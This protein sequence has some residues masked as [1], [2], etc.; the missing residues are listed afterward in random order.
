MDGTALVFCEGA[1]GQPEGKTANGLVRFGD[2][3]DILGVVDSTTA[4]KDAGDIL[5]D[6]TRPIPI[7]DT[8]ASAIE[9]LDLKPD[10]L[11]VGLNPP[12]G[13]MPPKY[14]KVIREALKLGISVDSALR[15]YL[16][17]DAEFPGLA[18]MT[19]ST[20]RSVGYPKPIDQLRPYTGEIETVEA[21][22]VAVVGT[23]S[24]VGK[25]TTTVRLTEA[26]NAM[27]IATEMIGTGET[28]WFQGVR[29]TVIL[30]SIVRRY[31]AGE[32]E[33]TIVEAW[34]R[35]SPQVIVLE[36]QGSV[37]NPANPSGLNLLTTARPDAIV[38]QHAPVHVSLAESDRFGLA[39]LQRHMQIA[40][41][42]S[43]SPVVAITLSHEGS[44]PDQFCEA[45][46]MIRKS[47]GLL[48]TDVLEDGTA[49]LASTIAERLE[50]GASRTE[51][52]AGV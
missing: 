41:L 8:L 25:R 33:A 5:P 34:R 20:L 52:A 40:E 27:G 4:G 47:F 29:S 7:F 42:L 15:P 17:D 22:R 28:S 10:Y 23:H 14:R 43:G 51:S 36:G 48:V 19:S 12:D 2:R 46:E 16:Q 37:M 50:G 9:A 38:M 39:T 35:Y 11:V 21:L 30:D 24:V 44:Q 6:I 32:M 45:K 49:A 3:Y 13:K 18:M 31:L 1:F 26:L